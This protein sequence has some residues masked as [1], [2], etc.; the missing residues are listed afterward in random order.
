[1]HAGSPIYSLEKL[2]SSYELN[3][4]Y[5]NERSH[6]I[7]CQAA[8]IKFQDENTTKTSVGLISPSAR[9]KSKE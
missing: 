7:S 2:S 9:F 1:M 8:M 5:P 6:V 4:I 3:R